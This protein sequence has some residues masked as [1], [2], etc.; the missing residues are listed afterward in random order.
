MYSM[1]EALH[2]IRRA[3]ILLLLFASAGVIGCATAPAL[4]PDREA[5]IER[6]DAAEVDRRIDFITERLD[7][8]RTHANLWWYGWTSFY[9]GAIAYQAVTLAEVDETVRNPDGRRADLASSIIRA[10]GGLTQFLVRPYEA[11]E[12]ADPIR[13]LPQSNLQEKRAQL[14]AAESLLARNARRAKR[15]LTW[16]RHVIIAAVNLISSSVVAFGY[17]DLQRGLISLGIGM[18]I[19]EGMVLTE[20]W[21]PVSDQEDYHRL[22]GGA[23]PES[24]VTWMLTPVPGGG[25]LTV[26]F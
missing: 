25:G 7:D 15:R 3:S 18:A 5:A 11:M 14:V 17:D 19:A 10:A 23:P 24:P 21:Q 20:P 4:S 22:D 8:T 6:M 9:S 16:Y 26:R 1:P 13:D 12:G 2:L